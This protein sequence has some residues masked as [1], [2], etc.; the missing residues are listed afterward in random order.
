MPL[1]VE[2]IVVVILVVWEV[3]VVIVFIKTIYLLLSDATA[4]PLLRHWEI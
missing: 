3:F 4:K 2:S 1:G